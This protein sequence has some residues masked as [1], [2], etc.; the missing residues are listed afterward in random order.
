MTTESR[1][2][3]KTFGFHIMLNYHLSKKFK[4]IKINKFNYLIITLAILKEI[5][6]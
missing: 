2:E 3:L 4:L 1:F 5:V 6:I